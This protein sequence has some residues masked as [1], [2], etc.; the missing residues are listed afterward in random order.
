[1]TYPRSADETLQARL[2]SGGLTHGLDDSTEISSRWLYY[3]ASVA[4][5][6][7]YAHGSAISWKE[8]EFFCDHHQARQR[9]GRRSLLAIRGKFRSLNA[10]VAKPAQH[11]QSAAVRLWCRRRGSCQCSVN[12]DCD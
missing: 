3:G 9:A 11:H 12:S 8:Q 6:T 5:R 10:G 7:S 4:W 2:K 1:M